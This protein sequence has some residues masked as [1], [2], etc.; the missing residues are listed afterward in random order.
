MRKILSVFTVVFCLG[1][2]LQAKDAPAFTNS[3]GMKMIRIE[4]GSFEMGNP[5]A[6]HDSWDEQPVH[7]VT[8]TK[9]FS[10]AQTEVTMEQFQQFRPGYRGSLQNEP[11]VTGLS[12]HDAVAFCEWLSKKEGKPYRLPT[13]AE[14]EY[15]VR[16]GT[17]TAFWSGDQPPASGKASVI[18]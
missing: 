9:P 12:W 2:A 7:A 17:D 14:W 1:F 18:P 10:M 4:P 13:E 11:Y 6:R 15:A 3:L 8:V 5:N 16:A